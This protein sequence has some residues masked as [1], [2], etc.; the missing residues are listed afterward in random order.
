MTIA[1]TQSNSKE[2]QGTTPYDISLSP[3][4][5]MIKKLGNL[6]YLPPRQKKVADLYNLCH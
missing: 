5:Y 4:P 1:H 2:A 3:S 6:S